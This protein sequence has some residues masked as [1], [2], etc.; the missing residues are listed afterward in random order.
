M[1]FC[2]RLEAMETDELIKTCTECN[3]F[4][5]Y[6]CACS[7]VYHD[8]DRPCHHFRLMFTDGACRMNGQN[9]ATAGIGLAHGS[10]DSSHLSL[11]ITTEI[12]GSKKRTSQRAELLAAIHGVEYMT[13]LYE[14]N[15]SDF[16]TR[17]D[18][19]K[20][21]ETKTC[22]VIATDSEYVV[23]GMTE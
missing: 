7:Q 4:V 3:D 15:K 17:D 20:R 9:G 19:S 10:G 13:Y 14:A 5:L 16:D 8:T 23:K 12:D 1:V 11:P 22:L 18:K 6:C 21:S 2:P